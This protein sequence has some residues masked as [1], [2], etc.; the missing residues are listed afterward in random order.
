M[1]LAPLLPL[2]VLLGGCTPQEGASVTGAA[3]AACAADSA[4]FV[5]V[6]GGCLAADGFGAA[7]S[8]TLV[9]VLHGDVST[10]G[11]ARYHR[12][13]ARRIAEALPGNAVVALVRPGYPAGDGRVSSGA[14]NG[15]VDHYTPANLRLVAEAVSALRARSGARRVVGVGHSGGAATLAGILALHP[16][17]LDGAVLLGCACDLVSMRLGRRPWTA[18]VD[19]LAVA[20]SVPARARVVAYTGAG[21]TVTPP[22]MAQ[23]YVRALAARGVQARFHDIPG[24]HNSVV[25]GVWDHGFAA[26]L[27]RLAEG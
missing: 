22:S 5:P 4:R 12:D 16:D 17:V 13:L 21:D 15:R 2:L 19:P 8:E 20:S 6:G 3:P 9:V 25:D 23:A 7:T 14:L 26:E 1:R 18:S 11:P 27:R 24:S 10:G